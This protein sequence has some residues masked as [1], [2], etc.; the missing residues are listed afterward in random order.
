[1]TIPLV[2]I[3]EL[4]NVDHCSKILPAL[5]GYV[6]REL[7]APLGK[8]SGERRKIAVQMFLDLG[9]LE[10]RNA[11]SVLAKHFG[12]SRPGFYAIINRL[13]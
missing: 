7:G 12:M 10:L 4:K 9:A 13:L 8:L 11:V 1:M 2:G 5:I 3:K 6:E